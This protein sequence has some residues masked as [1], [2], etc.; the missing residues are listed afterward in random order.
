MSKKEKKLL[1]KINWKKA[2]PVIIGLV[3]G[4]IGGITFLFLL[5]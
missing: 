2:I 1:I 4:I 5:G 3:L